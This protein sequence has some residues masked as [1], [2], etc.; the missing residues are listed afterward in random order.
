[1]DNIKSP[2]SAPGALP[3]AT[4]GRRPRFGLLAVDLDGT[5]LNSRKEVSDR[6]RA[7]LARAEQAGVA[8]AFISGRRYVE[9]EHLTADL[10]GAA[11]R[12]G[13]GGAL[14]RRA[15][16]TI[17]EFPLPKAAAERAVRAALRLDVP[18]LISERDGTVRITAHS[19]VTLR[20]QRYLR[21]VRPE[22]RFDPDPTF[23]EDPLHLV[24]A[25]T[26]EA[27][28]EAERELAEAL[29][30]SVNL[31]RTEYLASRLGLLD[32]LVGTANKGAALARIAGEAGLP[33]SATLAIGDNWNDLEMLEAAG[34]G[35]LMGNAE[36][37]LKT[38]G[39]EST[40]SHDENGVAAAIDRLLFSE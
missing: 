19:P 21:T 3:P 2:R 8:L 12:V 29:G 11:F 35:V 34:L 7:A 18:A 36:A 23:V 22:P 1:M 33:L 37:G 28:R 10:S 6:N 17:A 30:D 13:H 31:A 5:L 20:V 40:T 9:L 24:I 4:R 16:R 27:C 15:G 14:I 38:R 25:G 39:F 26:P 32:V